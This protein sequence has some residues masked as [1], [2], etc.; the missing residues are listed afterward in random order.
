MSSL[1][2]TD[3]RRDGLGLANGVNESPIGDSRAEDERR[4]RRR[5]S[6]AAV[7]GTFISALC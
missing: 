7:D 6:G 1:V 5:D 2:M 4:D 3:G